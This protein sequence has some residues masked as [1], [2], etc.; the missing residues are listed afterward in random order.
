LHLGS[1]QALALSHDGSKVACQNNRGVCYFDI[2]LEQPVW[3]WEVEKRASSADPP[4]SSSLA[5][6][7]NSTELVFSH[8]G[9]I[10]RYDL[11]TSVSKKIG[12]GRDPT[13][14]P[15]GRWISFR[16]PDGSAIVLE[17]Q[18]GASATRSTSI[19]PLGPLKWSP[20]A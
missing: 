5:W 13:W 1:L 20:E 17:A 9:E 15:D 10:W 6:S 3:V 11:A 2:A 4:I 12:E 19:K 18:S 8:N 14:S 7:H 16:A